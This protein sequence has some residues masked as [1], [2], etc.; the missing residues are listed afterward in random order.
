[1]GYLYRFLTL[2]HL[3]IYSHYLSICN[4]FSLLVEIPLSYIMNNFKQIIARLKK[5]TGSNKDKDVAIALGIKPTTF[6]SMKRRQRIPFKA[7]LAYCC[8]NR[9]NANTVLL[10]AIA[11]DEPIMPETEGKIVVKYFRSFEAYVLYL[12]LSK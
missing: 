12:G 9:I 1:M 10:G 3:K 6:A 2:N 5:I 4:I 7:V 11:L 8:D